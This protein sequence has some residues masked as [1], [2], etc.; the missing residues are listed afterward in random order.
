[1]F[2]ALQSQFD[3]YNVTFNLSTSNYIILLLSIWTSIDISLIYVQQQSR[4][5]A[6][7]V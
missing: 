5:I 3:A 4:Y 1:M 7:Q 2:L 6:M